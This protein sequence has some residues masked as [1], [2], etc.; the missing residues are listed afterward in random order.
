MVSAIT[1]LDPQAAV[2]LSCW[3]VFSRQVSRT[4]Q[5]GPA[6]DTSLLGYQRSKC[7]LHNETLYT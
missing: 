4:K 6:L 1:G 7:F 3:W 5:I 2:A